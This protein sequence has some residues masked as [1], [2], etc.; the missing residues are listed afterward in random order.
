MDQRYQKDVVFDQKSGLIW[1]TKSKT[2]K[3][4]I[5]WLNKIKRIKNS[6]RRVRSIRLNICT[7]I[8][9]PV[10]SNNYTNI[11]TVPYYVS[12]FRWPA[13]VRNGHAKGDTKYIIVLWV[14]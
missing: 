12:N 9:K 8:I 11:K 5:Y 3:Y 10:P 2:I 6:G 7:L 14:L 1:Y 4:N 13:N